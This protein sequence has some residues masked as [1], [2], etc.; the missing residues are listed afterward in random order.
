MALERFVRRIAADAPGTVTDLVFFRAGPAGAGRKVYIQ[1]ALHADEQ[2]GIM[3]IHHLLP[4]LQKADADGALKA[5]FVLFP[6]VN[7]LGMDQIHFQIHGGRYDDR[8]G[9]NFNRKWPDLYPV[10]AKRLAQTL[11]DNGPE[12]VRIVR[13]AIR[14]WLDSLD[15]ATA[16]Q[17]LRHFV[18]TEAYDAD[19]VLDL[20]CDQEALTHLFVTPD[21]MAELTA[22]ADWMGSAAQ[23]T[24][25]DSGGGSFDEVW[26]TLWSRLRETFPDKPIPFSA[27]A[28]TLEY[29]GSAD[30]F[31]D[32]GADDAQ[33]LFCFFQAEGL[34]DGTP[35]PAP[36]KAPAPTPLTATEIVRA[37]AP[38]LL[39]YRVALGDTVKKGQPI[40]DLIA[41][42]GPDAF[43]A[44][45]PIRA[46]TTGRVISR[47]LTKYVVPGDSIA[48]I[49]GTEPLAGRQ[50]YLLED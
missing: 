8:S 44:R 24:A 35:P 21:S 13:Q 20:H 31:D 34:I 32:L 50:S 11:T 41:L 48:K 27:R 30:V 28:A 33:N 40:A 25:A 4:L 2:P 26:P 29:R 22:L 10:V 45:T 37:L 6:M 23:L 3:V 47:K 14:D 46:G 7:P 12:N 17:K 18:M 38:G 42:D 36:R 5:S 19:Y 16:L 43:T 1:A 9:T 39:A 49:V 15:P